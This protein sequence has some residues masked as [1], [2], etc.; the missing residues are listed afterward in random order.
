MKRILGLILLTAVSCGASPRH[1]FQDKRWWAGEAIIAGSVFLDA[2]STCTRIGA[3]GVETSI[4]FSGN[5]SCGASTGIGAGAIGFYTIL[6]ATEWHFGHDDPNKVIRALTPWMVPAA[7]AP[8]HL[9]AAAHNYSLK[10][11]Q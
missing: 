7:I 9:S 3:R 11:G 8:I 10:E 1:W 5:R 4:V 2:H 6:H